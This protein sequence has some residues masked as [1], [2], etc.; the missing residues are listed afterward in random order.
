[1]APSRT[2]FVADPNELAAE[3]YYR[4]SRHLDKP[5]RENALLKIEREFRIFTTEPARRTEQK[6]LTFIV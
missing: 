5:W 6:A 1:M 3:H 2:S 4:N